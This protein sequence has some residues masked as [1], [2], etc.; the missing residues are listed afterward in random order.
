MMPDSEY[1]VPHK[2]YTIA[3]IAELDEHERE[4]FASAGICTRT[5]LA[6]HRH[7]VEMQRAAAIRLH[8]RELLLQLKQELG[9]V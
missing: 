8:K 4:A 2:D 3:H 5:E 6:Q 1:I 9:E 7:E